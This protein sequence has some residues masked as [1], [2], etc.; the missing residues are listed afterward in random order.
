MRTGNSA[1]MTSDESNLEITVGWGLLAGLAAHRFNGDELQGP[2]VV[3]PHVS[4]HVPL[5]RLG[6][7]PI[8]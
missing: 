2:Q 7:P 3:T 8:E 5:D 6:Q 4:P 1:Y